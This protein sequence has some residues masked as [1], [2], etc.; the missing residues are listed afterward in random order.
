MGSQYD[1]P[2]VRRFEIRRLPIQDFGELGLYRDG[3]LRSG[4][5]EVEVR[6]CAIEWHNGFAADS[7]GK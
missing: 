3:S 1:G 6:R 7:N 4:R 5:K 2:A